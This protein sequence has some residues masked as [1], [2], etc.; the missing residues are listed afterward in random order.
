MDCYGDPEV[1]GKIGTDIQENKCSWLVIQALKKATESQRQI[2]EV[3]VTLLYNSF[4]FPLPSL[5]VCV[6]IL[7]DCVIMSLLNS[8]TCYHAVLQL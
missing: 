7:H 1:I 6:V 4:K 3:H 5:I 2:L 8:F